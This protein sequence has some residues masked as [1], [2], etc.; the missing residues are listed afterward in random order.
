[1]QTG[2]PGERREVGGRT[3]A[4]NETADQHRA[5]GGAKAVE[6]K[7]RAA[8]S[9]H[10]RRL[11]MIVHMRDGKRVESERHSAEHCG[12]SEKEGMRQTAKRSQHRS[13]QR[14]KNADPR[15]HRTP[16]D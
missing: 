9:D 2:E 7:K 10:L 15:D 11:Q 16:V 3:E 4:C 8:R 1:E 5:D 12:E 13:A 6:P 14:R